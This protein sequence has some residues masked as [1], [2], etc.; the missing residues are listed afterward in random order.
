MQVESS[1][2][3]TVG[4]LLLSGL[5]VGAVQAPAYLPGRFDGRFWRLPLDDKLDRVHAER[6]L[7]WWLSIWQLVGLF[8]L[9]SGVVGLVGILGT[10]GWSAVG[11]GGY[12]TAMVFWVMGATLQ[13]AA[14]S[15][16]AKQRADGSGTPAWIHMPWR[17]AWVAEFAWVIGSNLA[18]AAIGIAILH[19]DLLAPWSGWTAIGLGVLIPVVVGVRRDLFPELSTFVPFVL[20]IATLLAM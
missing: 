19:S 4:V 8:L 10:D 13:A 16:A 15:E 14:G 9:T 5:G 3:V 20:G 6:R 12:L 11:L 17:A 18:Y 2:M 7:W 1:L